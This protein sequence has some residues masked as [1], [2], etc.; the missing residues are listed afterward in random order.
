MKLLVLCALVAT[1]AAWPYFE[2][3]AD[4][5]GGEWSLTF[6]RPSIQPVTYLQFL[7]YRPEIV[8]S[9]IS[10]LQ[11]LFLVQS[12]I[13]LV[14]SQCPEHICGGVLH[15]SVLS[16]ILFALFPIDVSSSVPSP[17]ICRCLYSVFT[18]LYLT[19]HNS[20]LE[21]HNFQRIPSVN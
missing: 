6:K 15:D 4:S 5:P 21:L 2:M 16:S 12:I 7:G 19:D 13:V 14:D 3:M 20:T 18:N 1:A 9:F 11:I 17:F 8:S 10:S